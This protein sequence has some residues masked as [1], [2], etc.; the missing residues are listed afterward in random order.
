MRKIIFYTFILSL[1]GLNFQTYAET[2][3]EAYRRAITYHRPKLV[4]KLLD[5]GKVNLNTV[6]YYSGKIVSTVGYASNVFALKVL[7]ILIEKGA[8]VKVKFANTPALFWIVYLYSKRYNTPYYEEKVIE[9]VKLMIEKGANPNARSAIKYFNSP[10]LHFAA[11][12]NSFKLVSLLLKHGANRNQKN[13]D[14]ETPAEFAQ[15]YSKFKMANFLRGNKNEDYKKTLYYAALNGNVEQIKTIVRNAGS[16]LKI[17]INEQ[18][19]SSKRTALHAAAEN[20][21]LTIVKLLIKNGAIVDAK[22]YGSFTPL[23]IA[24]IKKHF[25]VASYLLDSGADPNIEK[26]VGCGYST[27]PFKADILDRRYHLL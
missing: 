20:G 19:K 18:Q 14:N 4:K 7:K 22:D 12:S 1:I 23:Y 16:R 6:R 26:S 15:K 10:P 21:N 27:S 25:Q 17:L 3:E 11:K 2:P 9:L 8:N 24:C 13:C 5:E